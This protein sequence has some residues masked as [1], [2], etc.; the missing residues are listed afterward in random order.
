MADTN[1]KEAIG[2][3]NL[4]LLCEEFRH[5]VSL[6]FLEVIWVRDPDGEEINCGMS[7]QTISCDKRRYSSVKRF[8]GR[9][10]VHHP[11]RDV[12]KP[13]WQH[14]H[15]NSPKSHRGNRQHHHNSRKNTTATTE[16]SSVF[17][18]PGRFVGVDVF[19]ES[20]VLTRQ[21]Y[22][23]LLHAVFFLYQKLRVLGGEI[24]T[25]YIPPPYHMDTHCCDV[26]R[27][28]FDNRIAE[29]VKEHIAQSVIQS[30]E[31]FRIADS[32]SSSSHV[33]DTNMRWRDG[34]DDD[35]DDGVMIARGENQ[36][37]QD[38]QY[39]SSSRARCR[40]AQGRRGSHMT[41]ICKVNGGEDILLNAL[42]NRQSMNRL[43]EIIEDD[44]LRE[45]P[46]Y[47]KAVKCT[48]ILDPVFEDLQ[49]NVYT[50]DKTMTEWM[51]PNGCESESALELCGIHV[52]GSD[53][54]KD[55]RDQCGSS[56]GGVR[57]SC[58]SSSSSS[59][60]RDEIF[61]S[62]LHDNRHFHLT[63]DTVDGMDKSTIRRRG[64]SLVEQT[65]TA[66]KKAT[67]AHDDD[68]SL[69]QIEIQV[70]V[71]ER[72]V[73]LVASEVPRYLRDVIIMREKIQR[74]VSCEFCNRR[75][76]IVK[77]NRQNEKE[78]AGR[79]EET[80]VGQ[81]GNSVMMHTQ[82]VGHKP[83]MSISGV[84]NTATEG[85]STGQVTACS[86]HLLPQRYRHNIHTYSS[87][88][89]QH[90]HINTTDTQIRQTQTLQEQTCGDP[91]ERL[92]S[93]YHNSSS[94]GHG[95]WL[96]QTNGKLGMEALGHRLRHRVEVLVCDCLTVYMSLWRQSTPTG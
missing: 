17:V 24:Q 68:T 90:Q 93:P 46:F 38:R 9:R 1:S 81:R 56:K 42:Q 94:S 14:V 67:Q 8:P 45:L 7:K 79:C 13:A 84:T 28:D 36:T 22:G 83:A 52:G 53:V 63:A 27:S 91:T 50:Q 65:D 72:N 11:H 21:S 55:R 78:M 87:S 2:R 48:Q 70:I 29:T 18:C 3:S 20:L 64:S 89:E 40:S 4:R 32:K 49:I 74:I 58:S 57:H 6:F 37:I 95:Q 61:G 5:R 77:G 34:G 41:P 19:E 80:E 26:P 88:R 82:S 33:T 54:C 92:C 16:S 39:S 62:L 10:T 86:R 30:R 60:S 71:L 31:Y 59:S 47:M 69:R 73:P 43:Q 23:R 44:F 15:T 25:E 12:S 35:G 66:E 75:D 85:L 51:S 96:Q 76:V